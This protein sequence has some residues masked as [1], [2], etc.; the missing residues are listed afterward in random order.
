MGKASLNTEG[1]EIFVTTLQ[2]MGKES[3]QIV[4]KALDAGAAI[5]ANA[6]RSE[7]NLLPVGK[8]YGTSKR[9]RK[10]VFKEEKESLSKSLG[11]T[12]PKKFGNERNVKIGFGGY[13]EKGKANILIARSINSG[14]SFS[15]KF[16]FFDKAVQKSKKLAVE[17][18]ENI[19]EE[20]IK[21][22]SK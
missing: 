21:K 6:V 22:L 9:I 14:T 12:K 11:I 4:D 1:L 10:T 7:I 5:V 16:R 13:N 18:M 20:E 15:K 3:E 2:R 8:E 17:K 19:F